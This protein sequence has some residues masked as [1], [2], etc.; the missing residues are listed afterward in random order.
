MVL[1]ECQ[2]SLFAICV[3]G[4]SYDNIQSS[5]T[6]HAQTIFLNEMNEERDVAV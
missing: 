5:R 1:A 2:I 3:T 6:L 4:G